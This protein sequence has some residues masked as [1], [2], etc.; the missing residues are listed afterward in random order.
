MTKSD[1]AT[2]DAVAEAAK[3]LQDIESICVALEDAGSVSAAVLD[4]L[5]VIAA[6][7]LAALDGIDA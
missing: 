4:G 1:V 7:G 6:H 5:A 2:A 3:S